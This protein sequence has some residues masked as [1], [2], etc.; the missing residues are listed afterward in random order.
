MPP[1]AAKP[2]APEPAYPA[3]TRRE[4]QA[5]VIAYVNG[6]QSLDGLSASETHAAIRPVMDVFDLDIMLQYLGCDRV[7]TMIEHGRRKYR[8]H[9]AVQDDDDPL[10]EETAA[11]A[12]VVVIPAQPPNL[13]RRVDGARD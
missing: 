12:V 3:E 5:R 6:C 11:E 9:A 2:A 10:A 4:L 13:P 1:A 8:Y 7:I